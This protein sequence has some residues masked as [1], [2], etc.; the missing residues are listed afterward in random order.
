M[1]F[2]ANGPNIVMS[3]VLKKNLTSLATLSKLYTRKVINLLRTNPVTTYKATKKFINLTVKEGIVVFL[4]QDWSIYDKTST[5][6]PPA[7]LDLQKSEDFAKWITAEGIR[8]GEFTVI[9]H[10]NSIIGKCLEDVQIKIHFENCT[11]IVF[12]CYWPLNVT[13]GCVKQVELHFVPTTDAPIKNK[14]SIE[15]VKFG[16]RCDYDLSFLLQFKSLKKLEVWGNKYM[17]LTKPSLPNLEEL[18][19]DSTSVI[20]KTE[21][22]RE[23]IIVKTTIDDEMTAFISRQSRLIVLIANNIRNAHVMSFPYGIKWLV[24]EPII[25]RDRQI[26]EEHL[27]KQCESLE[28]RL[29]KTNVEI[30]KLDCFKTNKIKTW[31]LNGLRR[32]KK[33]DKWVLTITE[34]FKANVYLLNRIA[35]EC[36][37]WAS[38]MSALNFVEKA[39]SKLKLLNPLKRK[40]KIIP[41]LREVTDLVSYYSVNDD[42]AKLLIQIFPQFT[43]EEIKK[44]KRNS[45]NNK[46]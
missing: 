18:K 7:K 22:L 2:C 12:T 3:Y 33:E 16:I 27:V 34:E 32:E 21:N 14:N 17:S 23:L 1:L 5:T 25:I 45:T 36:E 42:Q 39:T 31:R 13:F 44:N 29:F 15:E 10:F 8:Q 6:D 38:D 40:T 4:K 46:Q 28:L 24:W 11:S 9:K 43:E 26:H 30:E 19:M 20:I 41:V 35:D 37:V